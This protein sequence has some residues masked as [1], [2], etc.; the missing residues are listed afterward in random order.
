MPGPRSRS[1]VGVTGRVRC[2]HVEGVV[3]VGEARDVPRVRA[4]GEGATVDAAL[5]RRTGFARG[6]GEGRDSE[7]GRIGRLGEDRRARRGPVD[8]DVPD[9][10]RRMARVVGRDRCEGVVAVRCRDRPRD[11]VRAGRRDRPERVPDTG[12]AIVALVGALEELNLCHAAACRVGGIRR[13]GGRARERA[14][15][16]R[17][18]CRDRDGRRSV[19]DTDARVLDARRVTSGVGRAGAKVVEPVAC[20]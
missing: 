13:E 3:V 11:A 10:R 12:C 5:E 15:D 14:V 16:R 6:E 18:R 4:R 9:R 17:G 8:V 7:V 19:V 20:R 2:P 1:R